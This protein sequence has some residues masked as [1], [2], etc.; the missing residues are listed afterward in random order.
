[1]GP[2]FQEL[3]KVVYQIKARPTL[4]KN[5]QANSVLESIHQVLANMLRTFELKERKST[6]TI[7]GRN[8]LMLLDGQYGQL[9][10][11]HYELCLAS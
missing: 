11:P 9:I 6:K 4:V 8:F 3:I 1:M 7:P 5:A 2:L 10:I